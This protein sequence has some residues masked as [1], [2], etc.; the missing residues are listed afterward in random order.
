[1]TMVD[2]F[3]SIIDAFDDTTVGAEP[4]PGRRPCRTAALDHPPDSGSPGPAAAGCALRTRLRSGR[5]G[6]V[7][8]CRGRYRSPT[9]RGSAPV[10]HDLQVQTGT[11]VHLGVLDGVRHRARRQARGQRSPTGTHPG[12]NTRAPPTGW[13]LDWQCWPRMPPE[14][15]SDDLA[16]ELHSGAAVRAVSASGRLRGR[17]HLGGR[18]RQGRRRRGNRAAG[19]FPQIG[20]YRWYSMPRSGSG[21]NSLDAQP[22]WR[23]ARECR[24][25]ADSA[26]QERVSSARSR[27]HCRKIHAGSAGL[28]SSIGTHQLL[29]QPMRARAPP[30]RGRDG[31]AA[32]RHRR[33]RLR[34]TPAHC[35]SCVSPSRATSAGS[36]T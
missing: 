32:R 19:R 9:S 15:A 23:Q 34:R 17:V 35:G 16:V 29:H 26:L 24:L 22:Q 21:G 20:T 27:F 31:C 10:L 18:H 5:A 4:R 2:R 36:A 7:V 14:D 8:G 25:H 30:W 3:T 28:E 11:V 13:R 12:R 1:M 33:C 6:D